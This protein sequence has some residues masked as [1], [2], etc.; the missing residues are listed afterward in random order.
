[1]IRTDENLFICDFAE[2]YNIYDYRQ[3]PLKTVAVLASGLSENSR[4]IM[5][6]S[7]R[8]LKT[9]TLLLAGIFDTV[10]LLLWAQ[11]KDGHKNKNRPKSIVELITNSTDSNKKANISFISGEDFERE[12]KKLLDKRSD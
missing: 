4:I 7:K 10:K 6:L 3:L 12:R 2:T 5:K 11:T 8:K 9:N 1:M